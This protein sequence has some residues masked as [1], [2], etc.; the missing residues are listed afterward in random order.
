MNNLPASVTNAIDRAAEAT[1]PL[2]R[3]DVLLGVGAIAMLTPWAT[4]QGVGVIVPGALTLTCIASIAPPVAPAC[5]MLGGALTALGVVGPGD[6]VRGVVGVASFGGDCC[7]CCTCSCSCCCCCARRLYFLLSSPFFTPQPQR[8]SS[9]ALAPVLFVAI[10][11]F[12]LALVA[13]GGRSQHMGPLAEVSPSVWRH[14]ASACVIAA[15]ICFAKDAAVPGIGLAF[16]LVYAAVNELHGRKLDDKAK[17][18]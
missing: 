16:A 10:F 18:S 12:Q 9:T 17:V 4:V 1:V 7:C 8:T 15:A 5:A 13:A 2:A 3:S 11:G 6:V 14:V